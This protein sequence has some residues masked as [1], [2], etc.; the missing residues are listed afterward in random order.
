[1]VAVFKKKNFWTYTL[2]VVIG[3]ALGSFL[4]QLL[5]G[6]PAFQWLEYGY[7]FA[8]GPVSFDLGFLAMNFAVTFRITV[9][10]VIGLI[11]ALLI[12]RYL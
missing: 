4:G 8:L 10:S 2:F 11:L 3:Y 12:H 5:G 1:M 7:T 9:S 6:I